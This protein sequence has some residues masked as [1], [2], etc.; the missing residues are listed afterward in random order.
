[1]LEILKPEKKKKSE[2]ALIWARSGSI[3]K[4]NPKDE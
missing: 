2:Y 3:F 4:S 1:M